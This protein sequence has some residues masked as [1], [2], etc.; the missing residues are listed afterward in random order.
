[1]SDVQIPESDQKFIDSLFDSGL[2]YKN[3]SINSWTIVGGVV[4]SRCAI[5]L[6]FNAS[7]WTA[8]L[9]FN[10]SNIR[11]QEKTAKEACDVSLTKHLKAISK[12]L[13]KGSI[14]HSC[15]KNK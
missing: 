3:N 2:I 1:M 6:N 9:E 11:V 12:E 7:L 5:T 14:L 10:G 15:I 8:V 13:T 4:G